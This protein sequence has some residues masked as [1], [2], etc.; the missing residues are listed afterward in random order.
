MAF[1]DAYI[2]RKEEKKSGVQA[3]TQKHACTPRPPSIDVLNAA[4]AQNVA[5]FVTPHTTDNDAHSD[6]M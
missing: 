1:I 5:S 2:D 4:V 3:G 6:V